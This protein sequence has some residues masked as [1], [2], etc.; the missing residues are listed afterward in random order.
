MLALGRCFVGAIGS[1]YGAIWHAVNSN[2]AGLRFVS[3]GMLFDLVAL[4]LIFLR[5]F[6]DRS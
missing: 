3:R 2:G 1:N 4:S 6:S 5:H